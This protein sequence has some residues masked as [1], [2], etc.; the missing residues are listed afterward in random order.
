MLFN[1]WVFILVYLPIVF[2]G[3]FGLARLR[4]VELARVWLAVASLG[5]YAYWNVAYVPLLLMS[6]GWNYLFGKVIAGGKW[7]KG[8]LFLAIWGNLALLG[9]YKYAGFF[10]ATL[11]DVAGF[12]YDVPQIILPLGISFFTFTQTAYLV[13]VYRGETKIKRGGTFSSYLLFVT[14]FPHLIAG[15]IINYR[16]MMPQFYRLRNFVINYRNLALGIALF[17]MGLFKKVCVADKLSP[18]VADVFSRAHSV[19]FLEAWTGALAYTYQLYFD[20]SG[21]SEMA[22]GLGLMF[23]LHFPTNFNSP[24]QSKSIID[25]WRR[26]HMTLGSWV[27]NYLY[28]PLGGNRHGELCKMRNLFVAML[29]IGLWHGAGWTFVLWGALHGVF[30]MINHQWRRLGR[31]LP[32][33]LAWGMTFLCVV[34][35]WV[36]FR[37]ATFAEGWAIIVAMFGGSGAAWNAWHVSASVRKVAEVLLAL[38]IV[39]AIMPNPQVLL[40]KF[41]PNKF[42]W[43]ATLAMLIWAMLHFNQYSEFLYFQF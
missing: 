42:W 3:Y 24:Y 14:I 12:A 38:T 15:P 30:L 27:K 26:W 25:F 22:I 9:Y 17:S 5:F 6:I 2:C 37:A 39:L 13:D 31:K 32:S 28:I 21:Y 20:F 11:N 35:C 23:N 8:M 40:Q 18:W 19:G 43:C 34:I 7:R 10:V 16:D 1:S 33:A 4:Y 36:F 29:L 41:R